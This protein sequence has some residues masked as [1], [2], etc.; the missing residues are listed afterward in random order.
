M[1]QLGYDR[2]RQADMRFNPKSEVRTTGTPMEGPALGGLRGFFG[3]C[4]NFNI[5]EL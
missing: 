1:V 5:N 4:M 2:E 3:A